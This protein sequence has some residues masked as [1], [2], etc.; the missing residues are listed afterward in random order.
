M[1]AVIT[2]LLTFHRNYMLMFKIQIFTCFKATHRSSYCARR[3]DIRVKR[4]NSNKL[5]GRERTASPS[6]C[7]MRKMK[8]REKFEARFYFCVVI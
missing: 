4:L 7:G 2:V 1:L 3:I 8:T 5:F 6:C